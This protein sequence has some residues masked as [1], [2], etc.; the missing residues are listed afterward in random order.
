MDAL[1]EWL[2]L[3]D[4]RI[5]ALRDYDLPSDLVMDYSSG[6]LARLEEVLHPLRGGEA[7]LSAAVY[8]GEALI[9]TGAGRWGW[10][11][12][13]PAVLPDPRT[14]LSPVLPTL[15]RRWPMV[16]CWPTETAGAAIMWR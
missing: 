4:A 5:Q 10:S 7:T 12:G 9:R 1:T 13:A 15:P 3:R 2:D 14:T 11:A 16:T 6:S 8:L